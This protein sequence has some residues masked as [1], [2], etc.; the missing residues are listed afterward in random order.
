MDVRCEKCQTEYELDE[1][2]LKPGGVTVK[3]THCGHM[4]KIRKRS[5]THVG[6]VPQMPPPADPR[7]RTPSGGRA[8]SLFDEAQTQQAVERQWLIRLENGEQKSCREL[9]TLQQWIVACVV[10]RESL[11][12]RTGK[13][14]KR[15]G[16]IAELSQYFDIADEARTTRDERSARPTPRSPAKMAMAD[17]RATMLGVG[18]GP[19]AQASGG[20]ILPDDDDIGVTTGT[21]PRAPAHNP[22]PLPPKVQ[23]GAKTPPMGSFAVPP[24][25]IAQPAPLP[26]T[27]PAPVAPPPAPA[28]AAPQM[29]AATPPSRPITQP[30][31]PPKKQG[32]EPIPPMP[33]AP[34]RAAAPPPAAPARAVTP[35]PPGGRSTAAWATEGR[36][37]ESSAQASMP[38][39]GKL[40]A[41]TDEPAF[42]GRVRPIDESGFQTGKVRLLDEEEDELLP[43]RRGSRAGLWIA[44][45]L[46][47]F[48][49]AAAAGVYLFVIKDAGGP[50]TATTTTGSGSD[51]GS[52]SAAGSDAPAIVAGSDAAA[53]SAE[54]PITPLDAA[55]GE[56]LADLEPRLKTAYDGLAGNSEPAAQVVRAQL[57]A[58]LAQALTD[59]AALLG[60]KAEAEKARKEAKTLAIE[61]GTVAQRAFKALPEDA[62]ANL[63]MAHVLRLQG[64]PARDVQR[65]LDAAKAKAPDWARD[66]ALGEALLL[67]R[68]GK[69]DDAAARLA[70]IDAGDGAL[71]RSNDV[72]ARFQRARVALAQNKAAEARPW[73]EQVL[74]TQP[75]HAAARALIGKLE[76][77]VASTDPLP[78]EDPKSSSE[79][80]PG[81]SN[82]GSTGPTG[83]GSTDRPA[84]ANPGNAGGGGGGGGGE[85][86]DSLLKRAN[87][88]A[89]SN[90][91]KAIELFGKAL[92]QK[93][94][95]VEALTGMGYCYVDAKQFASA[96][97]KFRTALVV[98]P[99]YEPALWGI[100]EA[101]Q[102]QGRKEQAIESFRAYLEA[103]PG[104]AKAQ[105][106]LERLGAGSGGGD[107]GSTPAPTPPS[108]E[109]T[110]AT[111]A[112]APEAP[113]SGSD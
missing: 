39:V 20:T 53:G 45:V 47:A 60:D 73:I 33:T 16:D 25:P 30:P 96:H 104:S 10:S 11:I 13:T 4:F 42:S 29:L 91:T 111:P 8:D 76:T 108:Q 106:Q 31:P 64:K 35:P 105:R 17:A 107:S 21:F 58:A 102:Q 5:N 56:L 1:A 101:Y 84:P 41:P 61:V 88:L 9:A 75:E 89:E 37:G 95:G 99:R 36:P 2:R 79:P 103:Y 72:R 50:K 28:A 54:S 109:P 32:S 93:P 3:C 59:R 49:G 6:G 24:V 22:P 34:A 43:G 78:P 12:S 40:S 98:S 77:A 51:A 85:S 94:N 57:G 52:G 90:C 26:P 87:A 62:G 110:P 55:R 14:W 46:L 86:Y 112:P 48:G 63:A 74:A 19:A 44:A 7:A 18:H 83:G 15:L 23:P 82:A 70:A 66:V 69:L 92:E 80:K 113:A 67:A 27:P 81:S 100:A 97:S 68:D 38:F 71:E 65:Y